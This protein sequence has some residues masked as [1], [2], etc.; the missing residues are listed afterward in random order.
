M[1]KQGRD[2]FFIFWGTI[3]TIAF[4]IIWIWLYNNMNKSLA[5]CIL[6]HALYN[7]SRVLFPHDN[8]HNPLVDYPHIHYLTVSCIAIVIIIIYEGKSLTKLRF[9]G[10]SDKKH[11]CE[12]N[13]DKL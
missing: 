3:G 13:S 8:L 1:K 9:S 2:A 11:I 4:R 5:A 6:P 12:I 7:F 10:L